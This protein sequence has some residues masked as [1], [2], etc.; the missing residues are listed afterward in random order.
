MTLL[1]SFCSQTKLKQQYNNTTQENLL[2]ALT[3]HVSVFRRYLIKTDLDA[4]AMTFKNQNYRI[5]EI[6]LVIEE[7][8]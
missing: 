2:G 3:N 6:C 5:L 4:N 8:F 1:F 7:C